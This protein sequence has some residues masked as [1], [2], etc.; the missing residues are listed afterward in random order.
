MK[1]SPVDFRDAQI[2]AM[3][4]YAGYR[5][6]LDQALSALF[7]AGFV[8]PWPNS[9]APGQ[10]TESWLAQGDNAWQIV[11]HL[12]PTVQ[13]NHDQQA[14]VTIWESWP[15]LEAIRLLSKKITETI[16]EL[17]SSERPVNT[18]ATA[19]TA[20][21]TEVEPQTATQSP[22]QAVSAEEVG[23]L[24]HLIGDGDG[25][26]ILTIARNESRTAEQRMMD[27]VRMDQRFDGYNSTQW[28]ELLA[29][30]PPAVRQ[31]EFWRNR[32][33]RKEWG[34]GSLSG[35]ENDE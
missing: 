21:T 27:L 23:R 17:A 22:A 19:S 30:R 3:S 14:P 13:V 11:S 29:V 20:P 12:A 7:A 24:L 6:P 8:H 18:A 9:N 28:A 26:R 31:T 16:A 33:H 32:G 25:I 10:I 34:Y 35:D 15:S 2:K 4:R 1:V 5:E